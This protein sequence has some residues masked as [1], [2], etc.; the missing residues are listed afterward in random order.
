MTTIDVRF[1]ED[2]FSGSDLTPDAPSPLS[3]AP[4]KPSHTFT[5]TSLRTPVRTRVAS[6][7]AVL[8]GSPIRGSRDEID[9][10]ALPTPLRFI[11]RASDSPD[12]RKKEKANLRV[13]R[14]SILGKE[15]E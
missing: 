15:R 13:G 8:Q 12:A 1:L 10:D 2:H 14:R 9:I 5:E 7:S 4:S 6:A 11:K 3:G